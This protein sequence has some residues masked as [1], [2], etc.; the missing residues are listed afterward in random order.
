MS[1]QPKHAATCSVKEVLLGCNAA[2]SFVHQPGP[3]LGIEGSCGQGQGPTWPQLPAAPPPRSTD[4]LKAPPLS[5]CPMAPSEAAK[6]ASLLARGSLLPACHGQS[7]SYHMQAE[8]AG[9]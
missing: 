5:C 3:L 9:Y 7:G 1:P 4:Q 2:H 6:L 8:R